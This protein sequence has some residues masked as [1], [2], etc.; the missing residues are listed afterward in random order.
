[1]EQVCHIFEKQNHHDPLKLVATIAIVAEVIVVNSFDDLNDTNAVGKIVV[2]NVPFTSYGATVPYRSSGA[3]I[4]SSKG[5]R[6]YF[7]F[8]ERCS[9][10]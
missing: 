4:A 6:I 10:F 8:N 3:R 5:V 1:M 9:S 7:S 2:Y